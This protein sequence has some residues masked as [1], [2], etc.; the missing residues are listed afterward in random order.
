MSDYEML[1]AMANDVAN[2]ETAAAHD[3]FNSIISARVADFLDTRKQD[4]AQSL[5]NTPE[6]PTEVE[7]SA[8][9]K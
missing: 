7:T 1:K 9:E 4:I 2:G 5:Y 3:K 8:E 6:L